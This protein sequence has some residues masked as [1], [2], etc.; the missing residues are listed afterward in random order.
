MKSIERD[1]PEYD[2]ICKLLQMHAIPYI[3]KYEDDGYNFLYP[4]LT[5]QSKTCP[6][7]IPKSIS[8]RINKLNLKDFNYFHITIDSSSIPN[9]SETRLNIV[10][11]PYIF[12][13]FTGTVTK[14]HKTYVYCCLITDKD[15]FNLTIKEKVDEGDRLIINPDYDF[16]DDKLK[17]EIII[18]PSFE[19]NIPAISPNNIAFNANLGCQ[20]IHFYLI[21]LGTYHNNIVKGC[22]CEYIILPSAMC[23][24]IFMGMIRSFNEKKSAEDVIRNVLV[25]KRV[26]EDFFKDYFYICINDICDKEDINSFKNSIC[27]VFKKIFEFNDNDYNDSHQ[28]DM[29]L[30]GN[31]YYEYFKKFIL[32]LYDAD[33]DDV[34]KNYNE[35]I[36]SLLNDK[37]IYNIIDKFINFHIENVGII[38]KSYENYIQ[39]SDDIKFIEDDVKNEYENNICTELKDFICSF[40]EISKDTFEERINDYKISTTMNR[41]CKNLRLFQI[42]KQKI[43]E[44]NSIDKS[45]LEGIDPF[46]INVLYFKTWVYKGSPNNIHM[47]FGSI[48][49]L[50][51]PKIDS[52]YFCSKE[53]RINLCNQ[54]I[55]IFETINNSYTS[56][57]DYI[58][59]LNNFNI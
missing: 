2:N 4:I 49:F 3:G 59:S 28:N 58:E 51:E 22:C 45:D 50:N 14:E 54:M 30:M 41:E 6:N 11:H 13:D 34:N 42:L 47:D 33:K 12:Y 5:L 9:R 35:I 39:L 31:Y 44:N 18:H 40:I 19:Q 16:N 15:N 21:T 52:K 57:D 8:D 17:R 25:S 48:S 36:L 56:K 29:D 23:G 20:M 43:E 53:D 7:N 32:M 46:F 38:Y 55:N 10:P 37:Y 24:K 26:Y 1:F 27:Y